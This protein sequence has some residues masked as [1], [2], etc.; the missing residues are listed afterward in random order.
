MAVPSRLRTLTSAIS[1]GFS[2]YVFDALIV[3]PS[4]PSLLSWLPWEALRFSRQ[5]GTPERW[6]RSRAHPGRNKISRELCRSSSSEAS[7]TGAHSR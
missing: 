1:G 2:T 7:A 3:V 4:S 6:G 5:A